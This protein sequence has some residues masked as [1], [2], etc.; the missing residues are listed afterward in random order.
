M[1]YATELYQNTTSSTL[2]KKGS[3]KLFTLYE[4]LAFVRE[5]PAYLPLVVI[6]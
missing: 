3:S 1:F 5:L 2:L 4:S 6:I